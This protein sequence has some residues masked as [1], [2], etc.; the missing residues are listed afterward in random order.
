[1]SPTNHTN[2]IQEPYNIFC[3]LQHFVQIAGKIFQ[4]WLWSSMPVMKK[5]NVSQITFHFALCRVLN[6]ITSVALSKLNF[7]KMSYILHKTYNVADV[8][9]QLTYS[10]YLASMSLP[11]DVLPVMAIKTTDIMQYVNDLLKSCKRKCNRDNHSLII[12]TRVLL[13]WVCSKKFE[14]VVVK[15]FW[16]FSCQECSCFESMIAIWASFWYYTIELKSMVIVSLPRF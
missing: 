10:Y 5:V 11:P 6:W 4:L 1:M 12:L 3:E 15:Q 13:C 14:V 9:G 8:L 7:R 16:P 2:K